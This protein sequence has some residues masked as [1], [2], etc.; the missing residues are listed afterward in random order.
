[1]NRGREPELLD[2]VARKIRELRNARGMTQE[3]LGARLGIATK[4]AQR[5]E[6]GGQNLTLRTLEAVA[7]AL[8]VHPRTLLEPPDEPVDEGPRID[9]TVDELAKA[10]FEITPGTQRRPKGSTEVMSLSAA[11]SKLGGAEDVSV[12]AWA[13]PKRRA[14][15]PEGSF[16]ARVEGASMEPLV[17]AGAWCLFRAP[18]IGA[19]E[20]RIVLIQHRNLSDP[21]TGGAYAL[22][23]I[24]GVELQSDGSLELHLGSLNRRYA[25]ITIA[26]ERLDELRP[27]AEFDRVLAPKV[28]RRRA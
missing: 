10:G 3:A 21:E 1:V 4:N 13:R 16:I 20:G 14:S 12:M 27:L 11:A 5:L 25:P 23:R 28:P 22:K 2:V 18:V 26:I 15:F 8:G 6:S 9:R 24:G 7:E 19:L 17:P